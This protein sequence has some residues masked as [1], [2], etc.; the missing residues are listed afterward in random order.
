MNASIHTATCQHPFGEG[1]HV[2]VVQ[3]E[4]LVAFIENMD[5]E[6]AIA[7][8]YLK[9]LAKTPLGS[10]GRVVALL[11]GRA[12]LGF[13]SALLVLRLT[14]T[15]DRRLEHQALA[16]CCEEGFTELGTRAAHQFKEAFKN[17]E[18]RFQ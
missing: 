18:T 10:T 7:A 8:L 2:I 6:G 3:E 15:Q 17:H 5:L 4:A 16:L 11:S 9:L 14:L 13:A 12:P 1:V